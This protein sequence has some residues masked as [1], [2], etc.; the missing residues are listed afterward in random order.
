MDELTVRH[1]H[2]PRNDK[3]TR[4]SFATEI[5]SKGTAYLSVAMYVI[6]ELED[7][8]YDCDNTCTIGSCNDDAAVHALD[9]AVAFYYGSDDNFIHALANK[10][11][12]DFATC[13]G[14]SPLEGDAMVN[15]KV[16]TLFGQMQ[17]HLQRGECDLA[18]PFV[19]DIA[20]QIWIP[21][22]QGTLRYA[23]ILDDVNNP[24]A[25]LTEKAQ[26]E[27]AIFAAAV[28]PVVHSCDPNAAATIYENLGLKA[29]IRVNFVE[30]KAAFESCYESMGISCGAVGGVVNNAGTGYDAEAVRP[31]DFDATNQF[32]SAASTLTVSSFVA[33]S[34]LLVVGM[35]L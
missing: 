31:C 22:I 19:N 2:I 16:F 30:V 35:L 11:C 10:R 34:I 12:D 9:E 13:A 15:D 7:A 24:G 32:S 33:A 8:M 25:L 14:S 26:A 21:I 4:T 28:L 1:E 6:R 27:G 5:V 17:T 29:N 3:L 20:T 23:W 18:R